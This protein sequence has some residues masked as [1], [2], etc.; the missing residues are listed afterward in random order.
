MQGV[1]RRVSEEMGGGGAK[2]LIVSGP[3]DLEIPTNVNIL[4]DKLI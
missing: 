1:K 2:K 3:W 4:I